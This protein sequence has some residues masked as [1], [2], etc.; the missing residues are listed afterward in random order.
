MT[1]RP[2]RAAA[3]ALGGI[4]LTT[5]A[6]AQGNPETEGPPYDTRAAC[7]ASIDPGFIV[8]TDDRSNDKGFV[9]THED[10][11]NDSGFLKPVDP[12]PG[13][14]TPA[15]CWPATPLPGTDIVP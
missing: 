10:I 12:G 3:F 8:S 5:V 4:L 14:A 9:A 7:P 1:A 13:A 15:A 2:I 11:S 6:V